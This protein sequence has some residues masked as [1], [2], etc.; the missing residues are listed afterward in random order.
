MGENDEQL[1]HAGHSLNYNNQPVRCN[2]Y[3]SN[4][5]RNLH[6]FQNPFGYP[7]KGHTK[8][9]AVMNPIAGDLEDECENSGIVCR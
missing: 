7:D 1:K 8:Y 5:D 9:S 4:K 6:I 3:S 2:T